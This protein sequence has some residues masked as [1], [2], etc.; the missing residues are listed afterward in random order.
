MSVEVKCL[1]QLKTVMTYKSTVLLNT[2]KKKSIFSATETDEIG[3]PKLCIYFAE[4]GNPDDTSWIKMFT[5]QVSISL[6]V[7][8]GKPLKENHIHLP[9][10]LKCIN[11][12]SSIESE[13][14]NLDICSIDT[15]TLSKLLPFMPELG[16]EIPIVL[17]HLLDN[18]CTYIDPGEYVAYELF[19]PIIDEDDACETE[20]VYILAKVLETNASRNENPNADEWTISYLLDIGSDQPIE[21]VASKVYKFIRSNTDDTNMDVVDCAVVFSWNFDRVK[22]YIR[23]VLKNAFARGDQEFR[24]T[25]KRL[26]LQYHPDKHLDNKDYFNELTLFIY[27]VKKRLENGESVDDAAIFNFNKREEFP[28]SH[29]TE[30]VYQRGTRQGRHQRSYRQSDDYFSQFFSRGSQP[31]QARRWYRQAEFD[32]QAS[33][34]DKHQPGAYNWA[35]YKSHQSAEKALKALQYQLDADQVIQTHRLPALTSCLND[36]ELSMLAIRLEGIT[37]NYFQMRYPDAVPSGDGMRIPSDLYNAAKAKDAIE[38]AGEIL[39]RV[40]SKIPNL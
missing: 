38:L 10:V 25:L 22:C 20:P 37:G 16:S 33:T 8:L 40:R 18:S 3:E 4:T 7:Y 32:F 23:D 36:S 28:R 26:L 17:H 14:D 29:F 34:S 12:P 30:N 31:G 1:E 6:N 19:D 21:V 13:L 24:R 39:Q 15:K 9:D 27:F 35:C 2:S 11:E 5:K